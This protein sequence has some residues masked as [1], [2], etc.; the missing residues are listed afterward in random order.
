MSNEKSSTPIIAVM[1]QK[2]G[3]GKTTTVVNLAA[4]FNHMK[5]K[6]LVID[7][8]P[9][10]NASTHISGVDYSSFMGKNIDTLICSS[11]TKNNIDAIKK[12][13]STST[14][15]GGFRGIDFIASAVDLDKRVEETIRF[16]SP[17]PDEELNARLRLVSQDYDVVLIDCPPSLTALTNNA[18]SAATHYITPV[19][20]NTNYSVDGWVSLI[21]HIDARTQDTNP[22]LQYLGALLIRHDKTK[23]VN[24]SLGHIVL[25]AEQRAF[26]VNEPLIPTYI[27]NSIKVGEAS[28]FMKSMRK[29]SRANT[30]THDYQVLA[31]FLAEKLKLIS[32]INQPI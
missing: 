4:E 26:G 5:L 21:N 14:N 10:G 19:D 32:E 30:V 13:I 7:L 11:N 15:E 16:S 17:R 24:K 20:S 27:H 6:V 8:D 25:D 31:K 28:I 29:L 12:C 22:D 18:A 23:N 2:G 3:V 1:T 9:Q